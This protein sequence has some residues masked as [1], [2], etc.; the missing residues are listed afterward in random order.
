MSNQ[1][2]AVCNATPFQ[3]PLFRANK[4]GKKPIW[5]CKKHLLH[6][7]IDKEVENIVNIIHEDN[8]ESRN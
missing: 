2:C 7:D 6:K 1:K 3:K 4:K 8:H 5:A